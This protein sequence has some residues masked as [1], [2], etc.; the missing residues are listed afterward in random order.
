VARTILLVDDSPTI[1]TL[2]KVYLVGQSFEFVEAGDGQRAL[3]LAQLMSVD[4][5]IADINMPLMDGI[6]FVK[7]LRTNEEPRVAK[8]PVILL[9]GEKQIEL[10]EKGIAAG[11]NAF[12]R[13]PLSA[14]ELLKLVSSLLPG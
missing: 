9:T 11:A 10:Q 6:Q 8:L 2:V 5:V 1:R 4:L 12:A 7:Q 3:Q 14:P 13:K